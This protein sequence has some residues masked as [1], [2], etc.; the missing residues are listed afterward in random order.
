[1]TIR[2]VTLERL[3]LLRDDPRREPVRRAA[4]ELSVSCITFDCH[5]L[6]EPADSDLLAPLGSAAAWRRLFDSDRTVVLHVISESA[7][8][9]VA[10]PPEVPVHAASVSGPDELKRACEQAAAAT[11]QNPDLLWI[12]VTAEAGGLRPERAAAAL[13]AASG[14]INE[15]PDDRMLIASLSGPPPDPGRFD[16][17][18]S[19]EC[20]RVPLWIYPGSRS[21]GS[22]RVCHPVGS[23]Q[24]LT[25][26]VHHLSTGQAEPSD[27]LPDAVCLFPGCSDAPP[28]TLIIRHG[29]AVGLRTP[30][31]FFVR[32]SAAPD[33][34]PRT[35]L[36]RKPEDVWNTNDVTRGFPT[37]ARQMQD[38]LDAS[39]SEI[40]IDP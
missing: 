22:I 16:T 40:P 28:S 26:I 12:H 31:F 36:Y 23:R 8:D 2:L 21:A 13:K 27:T 29:P 33:D 15:N 14:L 37:V 6:Q 20:I 18:L 17:L 19:E 34:P 4:A 1:M 38:E 10:V 39:T 25:T 5:L 9:H 3:S 30:D 7:A 24:I 11:N 32:K 35:A